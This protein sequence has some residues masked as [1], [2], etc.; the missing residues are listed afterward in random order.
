MH[1]KGNV[2]FKKKFQSS[3]HLIRV[4]EPFAERTLLES[5][6][7]KQSVLKVFLVIYISLNLLLQVEL[8]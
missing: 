8:M 1:L 7:L 5:V 6:V 4:N 3:K 2:P